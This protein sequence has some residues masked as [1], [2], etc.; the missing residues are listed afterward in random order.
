LVSLNELV[1]KTLEMMAPEMDSGKVSI[2]TFLGD[3][4]PSVRANPDLIRQA[5]LNVFRNS[6][7]AMPKGGLLS[8]TTKANERHVRIE[9]KDTGF[10]IPSENIGQIFDAFFTTDSEAC[11]LG[12]TITS[13]I[14]KN[15]G[16]EIGVDSVK[17]K[18]STFFIELPLP[19]QES[20]TIFQLSV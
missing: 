1:T 6:V 18:G 2:S 5:L 17:G 13:E 14:I 20:G 15:H 3:Q 8:V 12:L 11:G 9:I 10:G 7:R 19:N 16:G 4:L